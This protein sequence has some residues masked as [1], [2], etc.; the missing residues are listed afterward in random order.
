MLCAG[1]ISLCAGKAVTTETVQLP[2]AELRPRDDWK[3]WDSERL[4]PLENPERGTDTE[5]KAA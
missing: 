1:S 2:R 4:P 3:R 5:R